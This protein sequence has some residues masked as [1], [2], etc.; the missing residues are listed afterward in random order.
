[1]ADRWCVDLDHGFLC[2]RTEFD[3]LGHRK[4]WPWIGD[5]RPGDNLYTNSVVAFDADTGELKGYHQYHHKGSGF[6]DEVSAP[7][8][9]DVPRNGQTLKT[10]V[11]PARNGYLWMLERTANAINFVEAQPYVDQNV[12]TSIDPSRGGLNTIRSGNQELTSL[13]N[14]ARHFGVAKIG[15]PRR[16]TRALVTFIF[17]RT[18]IFV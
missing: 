9:I 15:L 1:M 14:F 13:Q 3:L 7:L 6:G 12:F 11:H 16:I 10:L 18:K 4:P 17:Q 2:P 8:L 5:Q